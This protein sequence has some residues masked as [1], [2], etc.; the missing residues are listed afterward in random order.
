MAVDFREKANRG[1]ICRMIQALLISL[2]IL[3]PGC[4]SKKGEDGSGTGRDD[5]K[6]PRIIS[7][8][9]STTEILFEL[10][11]GENVAGV[12][13][14][15]KYP[16]EAATRT[17][18]G[19]YL[20]PSYETIAAID[21]DL[22]ILLPEQE[23]VALYLSELDIECLTVDNKKI[24]D[25][26]EAIILIGSRFDK[27]ER[28]SKIASSIRSRI[29]AVREGIAGLEKPTVLVSIGH[30]FGSGS[31]GDVFVAGRDTYYDELIGLAGGINACGE[32]LP[33][34]PELSVEGIIS[35]DPQIIIELIP[36]LEKLGMTEADIKD[37]WR[38][39]DTVRA[40]REER[41]YILKGG[42][43]QIPGP[44]FIMVLEDLADIIH[45]E[46]R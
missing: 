40:V 14:F 16:P 5:R 17:D 18:V 46:W 36:D 10:G 43:S 34:Y 7:L 44:R 28:A 1:A 29:E 45:P 13:R 41:I 6:S 23:S 35:V 20:D 21:P 39:L 3:S 26:L 30:S 12:T 32:G 11:L 2:I 27:E 15:C 22:V 37:E 38:T 25:I 31:P 33:P 19:G 9:P 4:G 24:N 8:S 42:Y